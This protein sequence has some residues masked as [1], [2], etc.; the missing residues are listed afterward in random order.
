MASSSFN[1]GAAGG[2]SNPAANAAASSDEAPLLTLAPYI[3]AGLANKTVTVEL[4]SGHRVTGR[5]ASCDPQ[6]LNM[7]IDFIKA[8]A[9]RIGGSNG[10]DAEWM[11]NP[12]EFKYVQTLF[13][14][15]SSVKFVD[16]DETA[17]HAVLASYPSFA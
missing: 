8:T 16:F 10:D 14:R 12:R 1:V 2:V 9:V 5:M 17:A 7:T 11:P 15:G 3:A 4:T 6:T 13:V